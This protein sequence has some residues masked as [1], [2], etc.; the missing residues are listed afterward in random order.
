[1]R[2]TPDPDVGV[3]KAPDPGFRIRI[4]AF[5][6]PHL[7]LRRYPKA[8][9][10]AKYCTQKKYSK[11]FSI[12]KGM[13]Q[14]SAD[15]NKIILDLPACIDIAFDTRPK[16]Y[17]TK[18]RRYTFITVFTCVFTYWCFLFIRQEKNNIFLDRIYLKIS[19]GNGDRIWETVRDME[20]KLTR[21]AP[22]WI[23]LTSVRE[24]CWRV[25]TSR[26]ETPWGKF[27]VPTLRLS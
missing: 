5:T 25:S 7:E 20:R 19:R 10:Y 17:T 21:L 12:A 22:S 8:Y 3:K 1:M 16:N 9:L 11:S 14:D 27:L 24:K 4:T 6:E 2:W 18:N 13:D 26:R 15:P 23:L